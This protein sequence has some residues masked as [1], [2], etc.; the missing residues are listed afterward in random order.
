[1]NLVRKIT[2]NFKSELGLLRKN[3]VLVIIIDVL[4]LAGGVILWIDGGS[5]RYV[6]EKTVTRGPSLALIF[7]LNCVVYLLI[8]T[9]KSLIVIYTKSTVISAKWGIVKFILVELAY[10]MFLVWYSLFFCTRLIVFAAVILA[11]SLVFCTLSIA[12]KCKVLPLY[13]ISW[14]ICCISLLLFL[15]RTLAYV[16]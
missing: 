8:G 7:T 5:Y 6:I 10:L 2:R 16:F 1:M 12:G 13:L 11:L 9:Y 15:I 3:I 14:G 4:C